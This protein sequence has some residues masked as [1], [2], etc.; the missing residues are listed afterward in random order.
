MRCEPDGRGSIE[1]LPRRPAGS[2]AQTCVMLI[3]QHQDT[4]CCLQLRGGESSD[5]LGVAP[6]RLRTA[7]LFVALTAAAAASAC[8]RLSLGTV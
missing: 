7:L 5:W 3:A 6:L 4:A 1:R 2:P 8:P